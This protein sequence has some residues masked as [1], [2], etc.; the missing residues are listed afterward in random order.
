L[1]DCSKK[2]RRFIG[3]TGEAGSSVADAA[4]DMDDVSHDPEPV[5]VTA[6]ETDGMVQ[7]MLD[8]EVGILD[9]QWDSRMLVK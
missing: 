7:A 5:M 1:I 6:A 2:C 3:G 8:Q 9:R 4:V